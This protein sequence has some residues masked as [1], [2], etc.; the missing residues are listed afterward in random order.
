MAD[1]KTGF[2]PVFETQDLDLIVIVRSVLDEC[3]IKYRVRIGSSASLT[4]GDAM[5]QLDRVARP[6]MVVQVSECDVVRAAALLKPFAA[7]QAG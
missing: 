2:V 5:R 1:H 7:Q 3:T 6:I 4:D